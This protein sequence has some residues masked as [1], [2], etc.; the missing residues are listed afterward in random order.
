MNSFERKILE[1]QQLQK[2]SVETFTGRNDLFDIVDTLQKAGVPE[3]EM[4]E[5]AKYIRREGTPGNY[6]Y[7]YEEPKE[8]RIKTDKIGDSGNYNNFLKEKVQEKFGKQFSEANEKEKEQI[9]KFLKD[10]KS[11]YL[12]EKKDSTQ[13]KEEKKE[14]YVGSGSYKTKKENLPKSLKEA[15][16]VLGAKAFL[17]NKYGKGFKGSDLTDEEIDIFQDIKEKDRLSFSNYKSQPSDLQKAEHTEAQQ[18]KIAKV[19]REFKEGTLKSSSGEKVTSKE[20]ALAIALSEAGLSTNKSVINNIYK[21]HINRFVYDS[22]F[23]ISKTGKEL[24]DRLIDIQ[25]D[26]LRELSEYKKKMLELIN[27]IGS[28]PDCD[29][30]YYAVDEF[31]D[32]I[33]D[34]PKLYNKSVLVDSSDYTEP[35]ETDKLKNRYDE[36]ARQYV[37]C[38]KE[39]Q[40]IKTMLDNFKD[41]EKYNMT[42]AQATMLGF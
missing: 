18:K 33:I 30:N 37:E 31:E 29:M 22:D 13:N 28:Q 34:M 24:K 39:I 6:K 16:T 14:E 7:I 32:K 19:M 25:K 20:Q 3:D 26:E 10:V 11:K 35:S 15:K 38:Q 41:S 40:Y 8:N 2:S 21:A 23:K 5:K 36:K 17:E 4:I 9:K 1:H 12:K 27:K 42:V